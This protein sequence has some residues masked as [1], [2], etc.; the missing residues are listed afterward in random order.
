[1]KKII[2]I[3]SVLIIAAL[4]IG[5]VAAAEVDVHLTGSEVTVYRDSEVTVTLSLDKPVTLKSGLVDLTYDA[6]VLTLKSAEFVLIGS[7]TI[8]VFEQSD[9]AAAF[10]FEMPTEQSGVLFTA[11]FTVKSD[12]PFATTEVDIKP[13]VLR[14]DSGNSNNLTTEYTKAKVS[15]VCNHDFSLSTVDE[16]YFA[17]DA[18]CTVP[19]LYYKS[20]SICGAAGTD[21]FTVGEA[22]GHKGGTA[23]CIAKAVC[24]V[25]TEPYG[26]FAD[27]VYT[28]ETVK[29]EALKSA[30]T[31]KDEAVYRYSCA[32]CGKVEAGNDSHTFNGEKDSQNH[33]GG[34]K[35]VNYIAAVHKTQTAGYTGNTQCLGCGKIIANGE[36]IVPT[37]HVAAEKWSTDADSHWKICSVEGCGVEIADSRVA[38]V[39]DNVCD[40]SC[41]V[42][43]ET[44]T[45]PHD[46]SEEWTSDSEHHWHKC[47][48]CDSTTGVAEHN[49]VNGTCDVCSYLKYMFG[50]VNGDLVV[51]EDDAICLLRHILLPEIYSVNQPC[52]FN[53]DGMEDED[54]AI[55]LLRH[56]LLPDIYPLG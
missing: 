16:K 7:P 42:C 49:F 3:I 37:P 31:C 50:D 13:T 12:A 5:V 1:M 21:T 39:Y 30:G 10:V 4:A 36:A 33:A 32:V 25:C 48:L 26:E 17:K 18:T 45:A 27:H 53:K 20:C 38:H 35:T 51:D 52:D 2:S 40:D 47:K 15:V 14:K 56:S 34:T 24:T 6:N 43:G 54:D 55:Y 29:D 41:N 9:N 11:T 28:A 8:N 19:K 22:N 23:T 44:R 46:Y